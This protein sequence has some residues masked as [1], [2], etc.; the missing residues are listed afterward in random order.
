MDLDEMVA[1]I[2]ANLADVQVLVASAENGAPESSWGDVFVSHDVPA[3][4]H[5]GF[6]H[7]TIVT[8]DQPGF[9]DRS[10]LDRTGAYRVNV[11]VG[12]E[13]ATEL[14]GDVM[15]TRN[16]DDVD[17]AEADCLLPHP[18]HAAQGYVSV[19]NPGEDTTDLVL[20]LIREAHERSRGIG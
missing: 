8:Q 20:D 3:G 2:R 12:R 7:V 19:V 13:R 9:D 16:F 14:L 6:P 4:A 1:W 5:T 15:R 10:R 17:F 11:Q 18:V